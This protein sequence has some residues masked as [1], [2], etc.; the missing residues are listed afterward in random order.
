[1]DPEE[2]LGVDGDACV[3][4]MHVDDCWRFTPTFSVLIE[5]LIR[6]RL[7]TIVIFGV[8]SLAIFLPNKNLGDSNNSL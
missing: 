2:G 3:N 1:M 7:Q 4:D 6:K 8:I 5:H